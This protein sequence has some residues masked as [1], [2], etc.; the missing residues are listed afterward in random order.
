MFSRFKEKSPD[1][2][3]SPNKL[4]QLA[5]FKLRMVPELEDIHSEDLPKLLHELHVH[6][7]ELEMQN[8]ELRYAETR[9]EANLNRYTAIFE[10]SPVG[11]LSLSHDG[12]ICIANPTA[13]MMLGHEQT[14]VVGQNIRNFVSLNSQAILKNFLHK[15]FITRENEAPQKTQCELALTNNSDT[16]CYVSLE[17]LAT[18]IGGECRVTM[19]DITE[20]RKTEAALLRESRLNKALLQLMHDGVCLFDASGNVMQ[21]NP[22]FCEMLGYSEKELLAMN[23]V[24]WNTHWSKENLEEIIGSLKGD[25]SRS[26]AQYLRRDGSTLE[27]EVGTSSMVIDGQRLIL[28]VVHRLAG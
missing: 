20:R 27:V 25:E 3:T 11:Y 8:Q 15:S 7:I 2:S 26:K 21:A 9:A 17:G 1:M 24:Q 23:V 22:A 19:M 4:R 5:E 28:N 18:S 10:S 13:K 12:T 14:R 16:G 6:Q